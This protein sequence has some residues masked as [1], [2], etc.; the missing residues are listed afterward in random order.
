MERLRLAELMA[1]ISLATDLGMDQPME[2]ALRT[3]LIAVSL[4]N[5]LGLTGEELSEVYYVALLRFLGCTADA[6]ESAAMVGGDEIATRAAIA[7]VLGGTPSEFAIQVMPTV[8]A[9]HGPLRR[10]QLLAGMLSGGVEQGREGVRAGCE[11]AVNLAA[12]IGL[13]PGVQRGLASA[14]ETWKGTGFPDGIAGKP[15]LCPRAWCS[16]RATPKSFN[17]AA[18]TS[19]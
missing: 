2:Q 17:G 6:H 14:F 4:G 11:L 1:A 16:L 15:S 19:R 10:A 13:G 12:R 7:P 8:G 18:A 3:C 9:G 5:R